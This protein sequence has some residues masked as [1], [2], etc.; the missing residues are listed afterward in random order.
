MS[1]LAETVHLRLIC[2]RSPGLRRLRA[3]DGELG[4]GPRGLAS[5]ILAVGVYAVTQATLS[6][7]GIEAFCQGLN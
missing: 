6:R 2:D 7:G 1:P 5:S 4:H 3:E